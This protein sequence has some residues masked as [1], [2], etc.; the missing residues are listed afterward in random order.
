ME[1]TTLKKHKLMKTKKYLYACAALA[2]TLF[3]GSCADEEHVATTADRTGITSLTAYFTS[4][5]Y[6]DKTAV[7]WYVD[8]SDDKTDYV[9][10]VPYY[11]PEESDNSTAEA[12]KAMKV[13]A[14][15][16]NNC[17]IEPGLGV[18]DLTKK[19]EFTYTDSKGQ[20]HKITISGEQTRSSKCAM[21]SF[22][23][24]GEM[25]GVIDEDSKTISLVTADDLSACTAE[26]VLDAHATISPDPAEAHDFNDGFEFTVTADN[27]TDKAVYK[28]VKNVPPKTDAGY[29]PG[30]E[31]LM[32]ALDMTMLGVTSAPENVHPTLAAVGKFVVLNLGNGSAPQYFLKTTGS[33]QGEVNL[34]SAK[35]TGAITSDVVGNMLICNYAESGQT[36]EIYKTDDVTKAPTKIISYKNMLGV[37][38]GARLHVQG[39]LNKNAVIT[40]TPNACNNAIR[41]IVKDGKVGEPE[42]LLLG[43][44]AW[45]GLDGIAKV[46]A[47]DAEGSKGAIADYYQ[48]GVC[49]MYYMP[50]WSSATNLVQETD[51]GAWGYN[52]GA[53]DVRDFNNSRYIALFEMG[54]WPNW[55]LPGSVFLYDAS[56]PNSVTGAV[57]SSSALKYQWTRNPDDATQGDVPDLFGSVGYAADNRFA[58]VLLTPSADGYFLYIYYASNT[59]LSFGGLQVDCIKK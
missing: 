38:I 24:N 13:V 6:R 34:G 20:S 35:A 53:T 57:R 40:A 14:K 42:N 17:T 18:L 52:T 28:V 16:E 9:I 11:F 33:K 37:A 30:S 49:Q 50:T 25:T 36:L 5:E 43:I 44:P 22:I 58:D 3:M 56:N 29:A 48:G 31:K 19:N 4:G 32:F 12:M 15:L 21:K 1:I 23:V 55:G 47:L 46:C 59:H 41:W 26:V 54:Y 2:A 27:G 8:G 39:D 51:G 10:P 7:Q 45:G